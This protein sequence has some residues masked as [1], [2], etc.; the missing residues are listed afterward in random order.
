MEECLS[1]WPDVDDDN[2]LVSCATFALIGR[3]RDE[4]E[5][6]EALVLVF[7]RFCAFVPAIL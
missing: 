4:G 7:V 1:V 3:S 5:G 2:D 6:G